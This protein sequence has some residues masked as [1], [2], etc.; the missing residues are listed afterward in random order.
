MA[1]ILDVPWVSQEKSAFTCVPACI[2]MVLDYLC[3]AADESSN[4]QEFDVYELAKILKTN[5][6]G[7]PLDNVKLLNKNRKILKAVPSIEFK[8]KLGCTFDE[9][10]KELNN[11]RPVIAWLSASEIFKDLI[12]SVVITGVDEKKLLVHYND[13]IYGSKEESMNEFLS[14]WSRSDHVLIKLKIGR[15]LERKLDEFI[16]DVRE[17]E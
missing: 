9:I 6:L 4:I 7:T 3:K 17:D 8:P 15:L 12:H 2:K 14:R 10:T 1:G 11:H 5:P 13:P 16:R